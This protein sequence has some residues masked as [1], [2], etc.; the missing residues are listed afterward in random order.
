[1]SKSA[2]LALL[3]LAALILAPPLPAKEEEKAPAKPE[4][5]VDIMRVL[6]E[7]LRGEDV[8]GLISE[9]QKAYNEKRYEDAA[10]AYIKA[11]RR[12]PGDSTALYNLAC[13]Y[14]LLG[15]EIQA[16]D[17]LRAAW[18]AG[19]R[20]LEH[21]KR[22]PD[23]D[24]VRESRPFQVLV[25]WLEEKTEEAREARGELLFVRSATLL[26]VHVVAPPDPSPFQRIPLVIGLHGLGDTAENFVTLFRRRNL[27]V[28]FLFVVPE[29]PYVFSAGNRPGYSWGLR[30]EDAKMA[31]GL[32][33]HELTKRYV[34]DVVRA[35]KQ[36]YLVDETEVYLLG[37]SQGAGLTLSLGL[38]HPELFRGL[39]PIGGWLVKGEHSRGELKAAARLTRVLVCHSPEDRM[40]PFDSAENAV[41]IL[42]EAGV[43][44][45]LERYEG[46]HSLPKSILS[47]V[48][49]WIGERKAKE[50]VKPAK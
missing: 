26:P 7:D 24:K 47:E 38:E 6:P 14:G 11:L 42:R 21:I 8:S 15:A 1:M 45:R 2:V 13:C 23:F 49:G 20:D 32:R 18:V 9:A 36:R 30:N 31:D 4:R 16:T 48:I 46:G 19:F 40:V 43:E 27:D 10:I 12:N 3:F 28:P 25:D 44:Y 17:F 35:V 41:K 39:I 50:K 29:A 33:A 5:D 37:F 34:L 22:D